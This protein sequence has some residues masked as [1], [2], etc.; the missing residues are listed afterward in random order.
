[1]QNGASGIFY[2]EV[3][4]WAVARTLEQ[5]RSYRFE[6]LDVVQSRPYLYSYLKLA[7]G[8]K[9][10]NPFELDFADWSLGRQVDMGNSAQ[11][12]EALDLTVCP[13][14]M[15]WNQYNNNDNNCYREGI[16]DLYVTIYKIPDTS[17]VVTAMISQFRNTFLRD[18][19]VNV[20]NYQWTLTGLYTGNQSNSNLFPQVFNSQNTQQTL[21]FGFGQVTNM[22]AVYSMTLNMQ[23]KQNFQT[24]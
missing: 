16:I 5:I 15:Y 9:G 19:A 2:S 20:Y 18:D 12:Q 22:P 4:F 10:G 17:Y 13:L 7:D 6:Q 23:D 3:R 8:K 14:Y 21:T 24:P 11:W 1:M